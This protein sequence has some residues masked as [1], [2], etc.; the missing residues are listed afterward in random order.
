MVI[1]DLHIVC[2][3]IAPDKTDTELIV[4]FDTRLTLPVA[5]QLLKMISW[6]CNQILFFLRVMKDDQF[7]VCLPV[8]GWWDLSRPYLIED[9]L[10]FPAPKCLYHWR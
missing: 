7:S 2:I 5:F 9:Q 10:C 4:Y 1:N 6:Q 8:N 3:P